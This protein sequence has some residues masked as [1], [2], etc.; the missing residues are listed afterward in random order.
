MKML[1]DILEV[2]SEGT[3][4]SLNL[5]YCVVDGVSAYFEN[6]K[7]VEVLSDSVITLKVRGGLVKIKGENLNIRKYIDGD[8]TV[9][10]KINAVEK[11]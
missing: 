3:D 4:T 1:R 2:L 5:I 8:V 10:G 6:V 9:S 7:G 11:Y